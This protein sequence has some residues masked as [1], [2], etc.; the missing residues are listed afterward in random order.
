MQIDCW[1]TWLSWDFYSLF[2]SASGLFNAQ[3]EKKPPEKFYIQTQAIKL[4][5]RL[6]FFILSRLL[7]CLV[8]KLS[9]ELTFLTRFPVAWTCNNWLSF[10]NSLR[11]YILRPTHFYNIY[12]RNLYFLWEKTNVTF[13]LS[14]KS[15]SY[16]SK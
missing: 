4:S 7:C 14:K 2:W 5:N 12:K 9:S 13:Q 3:Y 8:P 1:T 11:S 15:T 6:I 16:I 10:L